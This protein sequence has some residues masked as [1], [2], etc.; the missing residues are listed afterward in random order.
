MQKSNKSPKPATKKPSTQSYLWRAAQILEPP[1]QF[2][3]W[4]QQ[5]GLE[6]T[7]LGQMWA[8][9][10][11]RYQLYRAFG[12]L[13]FCLALAFLLHFKLDVSLSYNIGDVANADIRSPITFDWVDQQA[14]Q[15]QKQ[16][17]EE[18]T[19]P[20]FDFNPNIYRQKRRQLSQA[21]ERM[22]QLQLHAEASPPTKEDFEETM[23][24]QMRWQESHFDWLLSMRFSTDIE[25]TI[26]EQFEQLSR[27]RI[28]AD[29]SSLPNTGLHIVVR[30]IEGSQVG[31]EILQPVRQILNLEQA[32]Q[33][34]QL[35][36]TFEQ[37]VREKIQELVRHLL[38]PNLTLNQRETVNR[39][40]QAQ[41]AIPDV[42]QSIQEGQVVVT[43]GAVV[44]PNHVALLG[45]IALRKDSP[46][47]TTVVFVVALLFAVFIY[48]LLSELQ[49]VSTKRSRIENKD[50][51]VMATITLI[52][53]SFAQ[54]TTMIVSEAISMK[55]HI[56]ETQLV[57]L[58]PA[59]A[60][61]MLVALLI[62]TREMVWLYTTFFATVLSVSVGFHFEF[63]IVSLIG[64]FS[65]IRG[66]FACKKR[67]DIYWAGLRVGVIN[68][69]TI[70][71]L[72][73]GTNLTGEIEANH[74]F[75]SSLAGL[76]S[77]IASS[78]VAMMLVP[79]LESLFQYT[80]DVKLLEL[81]NL[82]HPLLKEMIVRAPGTYHHS[83]VVGSMVEAAAEAIGAN[84]L[85]AKV[86]SYYH[87]IGKMS[88]AEYFIENQR[89][90][91]NP[92]DQLTPHMSKTV[93]VAH[94]KDGVDLSRKHKLGRAITDV[95]SQHH[96]TT[97]IS[98][99]YSRAKQKEKEVRETD[100]RYPG[101]KP[102]F[103]ESALCMLADSIEA[104]ARSLEDPSPVCLKN[105]VRDTVRKK[106]VDGQ[107]NECNLTLEEIAVIER[108][109]YRVLLGIYHQR[110]DYPS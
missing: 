14:T 7:F 12:V 75:Y 43:R 83:L 39:K 30:A 17:A 5:L 3:D 15:Q 98:Y 23:E 20:V 78:F 58:I 57:Y 92:H 88:H 95:I 59:A 55:L 36:S 41:K 100:F 26:L 67:N 33:R 60:A 13:L 31:E 27:Y 25:S 18:A 45:E 70:A 93:I 68:M 110:I 48:V 16:Q 90:G 44:Q 32:R 49:R 64:G 94:V 99:F 6:K 34:V 63:L 76:I 54:F 47:R 38:V 19:P 81:S 74:I 84:S 62:T 77:G 106:I 53:S 1:T 91:H 46:Y 82:N 11:R 40:E 21:F 42:V 51:W 97:L 61:P 96:G 28:V 103:V 10:E 24:G 22:R 87:D 52:M 56:E 79:M 101:P 50:L 35:D 69:I 37:P 29:V 104:T 108:A 80:T 107:L 66:V 8:P 85:L 4:A 72:T 89:P 109:F 65:G 2:L 102:Q 71:L 105:L 73:F 86:A 9:F